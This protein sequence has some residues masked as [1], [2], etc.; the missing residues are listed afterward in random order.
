MKKAFLQ[1]ANCGSLSIVPLLGITEFSIYYIINNDVGLYKA[2][3]RRRT[4]FNV[5]RF[6]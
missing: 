4:V 1:V 6:D 5:P 3:F 2:V